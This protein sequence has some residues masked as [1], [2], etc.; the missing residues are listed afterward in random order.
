[1]IIYHHDDKDGEGA[2]FLVYNYAKYSDNDAEHGYDKRCVR[3]NYKMKFPLEMVRPN[4]QVWIVDY[5]ISPEEMRQLLMVTED[6]IW[7]D[8]HKSAIDKYIGFE[9]NLKG[10]RKNGISGCMLTHCYLTMLNMEGVTHPDPDNLYCIGN[11]PEYVKLIDDWDIHPT[12]FK[13]GDN[14]R[15]F[16]SAMYAYDFNPTSP[17]W[18]KFYTNKNFVEELIAEGKGIVKYKSNWAKLYLSIGYATEFE[19]HKC[20][21]L[22]MGM[23]SSDNFESIADQGYD[24]LMPFSYDG[25]QFKVT[26]Y[27]VNPS[28]DMSKIAEKYGGG[29]HFG[30]AGFQCLELPFKKLQK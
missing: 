4:E 23:C 6:I 11:C 19:G 5:S 14:T 28:L 25:E 7:I 15:Y 2:G 30:A 1:M 26:M 17:N 16:Q 21:A 3:I 20:F 10:L 29:G 18:L 8:H 27:R 9:Y 24:I 22:N 12:P 13:Y